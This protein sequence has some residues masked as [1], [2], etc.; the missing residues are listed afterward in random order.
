[1]DGSTI[2]I[3]RLLL[4]SRQLHSHT[5]YMITIITIGIFN[6]IIIIIVIIIIIIIIIIT[7]NMLVTYTN[8][9]TI[10]IIIMSIDILLHIKTTNH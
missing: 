7:R 8:N 6:T 4:L 2:S 10:I 1:M 9:D 3:K 5:I